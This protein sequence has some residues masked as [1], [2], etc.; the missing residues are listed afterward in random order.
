LCRQPLHICEIKNFKEDK[1]YQIKNSICQK[2]SNGGI[3]AVD[4]M[5]T[6]GGMQGELQGDSGATARGTAGEMQG[7]LQGVLQG[8][9]QG[10]CRG[11]KLLSPTLVQKEADSKIRAALT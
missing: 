2:A 6:A 3:K 10:N 4:S 7:T 8:A 1:G 11:D 9:L 5:G